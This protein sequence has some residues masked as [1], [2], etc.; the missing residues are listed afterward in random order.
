[1]NGTLKV[2]AAHSR[3]GRGRYS[4]IKWRGSVVS[5]A[6]VHR[7]R[8]YASRPLVPFLV[9]PAQALYTSTINHNSS[10]IALVAA[11]TRIK[12]D[13]GQDALFFPLPEKLRL[14]SRRRSDFSLVDVLSISSSLSPISSLIRFSFIYFPV[15]H[16]SHSKM[17]G[18]RYSL[19]FFSRLIGAAPIES[20]D[21]WRR[22]GSRG[23]AS[24]S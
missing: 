1:M 10:T 5:E 8:F 19:I 4:C 24:F 22:G 15:P 21:P 11:V 6:A 7:Q 23:A 14:A 13:R 16:A 12:M 2:P 18:R 9:S 3:E 20:Q 17:G